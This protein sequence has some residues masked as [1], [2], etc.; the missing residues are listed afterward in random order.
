M[1]D[2]SRMRTA[3]SRFGAAIATLD[4]SCDE[5]ESGFRALLLVRTMIPLLSH[6]SFAFLL[7]FLIVPRGALAAPERGCLPTPKRT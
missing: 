7:L 1:I 2:E 4:V 6:L 5:T 3:A